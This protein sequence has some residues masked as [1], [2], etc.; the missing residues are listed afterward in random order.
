MSTL[1]IR[2]LLHLNGHSE[3]VHNMAILISKHIRMDF[4]T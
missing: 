1:R 3:H 4:G 2:Y